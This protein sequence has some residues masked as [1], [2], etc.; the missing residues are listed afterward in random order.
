VIKSG[1]NQFHGEVVAYGSQGHLEASNLT[2]ALTAAGVKN[3]PKLHGM[4]DDSGNVGGRIVRDKLWFFANYRNQGY[5]RDI[6]NAFYPDGTTPMQTK[7]KDRLFLG[8]VSLQVSKSNKLT[9]FYHSDLE[10]QRRNGSQFIGRD[11]QEINQGP[12]LTY[13]LSWQT[14]KAIRS[15]WR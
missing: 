7:T 6:L 8:K 13:G 11:G 3:P 12:F 9:G 10:V 2:T 15:S 1:S 14:V 5:N 4:W